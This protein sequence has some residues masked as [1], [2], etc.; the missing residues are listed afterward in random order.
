M[1]KLTKFILLSFIGPFVLTFFI[2]VFVLLM[3]FI[4]LY[5]DDMI[6]KGIEWYV[7]AELLFY[8][9]ANVV[10]LAL[11]LAVLLSS[12]MTFGSL[13]EHFELVSFK[14]AGISLQRI[15]TPL[16]IFVL[17]ISAAAF[18]FS[19]YIMPAANLKFYA[20]LY[21]IRNKKPAV[22]I[23]PGVF[24][25]EID[26]YT[27]RVMNKEKID[28][29]EEML[30]DVMIYN[31]SGNN[32]NRQL[33]VADSALMKMSKDKTYFSIKLFHGTDYQDKF[34]ETTF[35]VH[36]L[37]RF[38][39]DENE[40]RISLAGFQF[41]RTDED[42]FKHDYRLFN[43][44]QLTYKS[45]TLKKQR[46]D[47]LKDFT[48]LISTSYI[49]NDTIYNRFNSDSAATLSINKYLNRM[50]KN[51]INQVY[52]VALASARTN[53]GRSNAAANE[54]T[55]KKSDMVRTAIEWHRKITFS[56]AC[57][58][59]FLIGAPLGAI[60]KKGGLGMPVV[61]SVIFFLFFWVTTII[62]EDMIKQML[63]LPYQGM[64]A[65]T[66]ILLPLGLFFTYKATTDSEMF[67]F[68]AYT[69][70]FTKIFKK[71]K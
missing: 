34:E 37:S 60:V 21:D 69:N 28:G 9:S 59:M 8:S 7:I 25:N 70:F 30:R 38:K 68:S 46:I 44:K 67:N 55:I 32:G 48:N 24:Y 45:D 40:M 1:K 5:V 12:L 53:K 63:I 57:F 15:M 33:T 10:P 23:K 42:E 16:A 64:W 26:G 3:Q 41:N 58:I 27:I 17:I 71:G 49:F 36:P 50:D 18:S 65:A 2:A 19:N 11:P 14:A 51:T 29:G 52:E 6:G 39:F 54:I 56:L 13:G 47:R 35:K 4:W 62:G 31:H 43:L 61:I 22:N 20:L 66:A